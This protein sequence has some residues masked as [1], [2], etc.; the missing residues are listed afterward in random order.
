MDNKCVEIFI[1]TADFEIKF[2]KQ[3]E[4]LFAALNEPKRC[5]QLHH[6]MSAL[7]HFSIEIKLSESAI[8]KVVPCRQMT[9]AFFHRF[10]IITGFLRGE[11]KDHMASNCTRDC[12]SNV[13]VNS[14]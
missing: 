9:S 1:K 14:L 2:L 10:L 7:Q 4:K 6:L 13:K 11:K 5:K 3:F 8:L 12:A